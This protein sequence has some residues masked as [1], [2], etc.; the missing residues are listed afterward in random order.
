LVVIGSLCLLAACNGGG[1]G[2]IALPTGFIAKVVA[3]ETTT[4]KSY[5]RSGTA[6]AAES[7]GTHMS[8]S[9]CAIALSS[10]GTSTV[11]TNG[12]R[13][14]SW[15]VI[16]QTN[17][18][19]PL[20]PNSDTFGPQQI[21]IIKSLTSFKGQ[22][23]DDEAINNPDDPVAQLK[24]Y[25]TESVSDQ[26]VESQASY[27]GE[28]VDEYYILLNS[29]SDLWVNL[30]RDPTAPVEPALEPTT[31]SATLLTR[32]EPQKGDIWASVDGKLLYIGDGSE[33][34]K[35]GAKTYKSNRIKVYT[36]TGLDPSANDVLDTCITQQARNATS[37]ISGSMPQNSDAAFLNP[38]CTSEFVH[39][40]VGTEWWYKGAR[41]KYST[42][43]NLVE[44]SDYGYEWTQQPPAPPMAPCVRQKSKTK[45]NDNGVVF[46]EYKVTT[47]TADG[48]ASEVTEPK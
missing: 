27:F 21:A 37:S 20:V 11:T 45:D 2:K 43:T 15:E 17:A 10:T 19:H 9:T 38:N 41:L 23:T 47:T 34:L 6:A 12:T 13:E 44:I 36:V 5:K 28:A 46:V 30:A 40:Q 48:L 22:Q 33:D 29:L 32:F 25:T 4:V 42:I 16:G 1:A 8:G 18:S 31:L 3:A 39:S 24:S 26:G 35:I 14:T 7:K